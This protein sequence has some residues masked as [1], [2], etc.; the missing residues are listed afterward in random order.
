MD[1][2]DADLDIGKVFTYK[3]WLLTVQR[4][5]LSRWVLVGEMPMLPMLPIPTVRS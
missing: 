4:R 2:G 3:P 5:Y 1:G